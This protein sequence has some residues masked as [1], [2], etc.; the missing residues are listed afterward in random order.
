MVMLTSLKSTKIIVL[1]GLFN[2]VDLIPRV[3]W[4]EYEALN[5][6]QSTSNHSFVCSTGRERSLPGITYDKKGRYY[7]ISYHGICPHPEMK[8]WKCNADYK[9]CI[10]GTTYH[11]A[12]DS[13]TG[14]FTDACAS[15]VFCGKGKEPIIQFPE[16]LAKIDCRYCDEDHFSPA[17][18]SSDTYSEC[19]KKANCR[20]G[21]EIECLT[22]G[23][24]KY[25]T[26]RRC[27]CNWKMNYIPRNL[28]TLKNLETTEKFCLEDAT[29]I[30][31]ECNTRDGKSQQR[32]PDYSCAEVCDPDFHRINESGECVLKESNV[33]KEE[34][35]AVNVFS[36]PTT[37]TTTT[38]KKL[39]STL[40]TDITP[41]KSNN[42]S[43]TLPATTKTDDSKYWVGIVIGIAIMIIAVGACGFVVWCRFH[44]GD[45][46]RQ[47][48]KSDNHNPSPPGTPEYVS[49]TEDSIQ[50]RWDLPDGNEAQSFIAKYK[51]EIREDGQAWK[52][53]GE[54]NYNIYTARGLKQKTSYEF[55]V[56]TFYKGK[57]FSRVSDPIQLQRPSV[58]PE[59]RIRL[60]DLLALKGKPVIIRFIYKCTSVPDV[61]WKKG[62]D[63][64]EEED[65]RVT[66][67]HD[68][69]EAACVMEIRSAEKKDSGKYTVILRNE[70][71]SCQKSFQIIVKDVPGMPVGP[72]TMNNVRESENK[73]RLTW[74]PPEDNGGSEIDNYVV[75]QKSETGEWKAYIAYVRRTSCILDL[76]QEQQKYRFRVKAKNKQGYSVPCE[77]ETPLSAPKVNQEVKEYVAVEGNPYNVSIAYSGVPKPD[78]RWTKDG[79]AIKEES[80][81]IS[82]KTDHK[83]I[84]LELNPTVKTDRG[85]YSVKLRNLFGTDEVTFYV[86]IKYKPGKPEGP[87][88]VKRLTTTEF[89]LNWKP[90]QDPG[91][92]KVKYHVE[93][94][95][96]G[97]WVEKLIT[98]DTSCSFLSTPGVEQNRF[99]VMAENEQGY[100]ESLEGEPLEMVVPEIRT[101]LGDI[102]ARKGT[103]V[104][105]PVTYKCT[106]VPEVI[107]KKGDDVHEEEDDRVTFKHDDVEAACVMEVRSAE[108]KDSGKY[109][110]ILKNEKGSCQKSFQIIV[111]DVP[112]MPVGPL[113]VNNVLESENKYQL[114]W[115]APED[116]GGSEIDNYVVEQKS[117]TEEWEPY[118]TYVRETSCILDL[119]QERKKYRFRVKAQ[120]EQ[121]FS[122]PC[123][124]ETPFI[125]SKL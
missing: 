82:F 113:T 68:D 49:S 80:E 22:E 64:H 17:N 32:L 77:M 18:K 59:I 94:S 4:G 119:T 29:C 47:N 114:T 86:H 104:T 25:W 124:M 55:R 40:S 100:G 65:D 10:N 101:R 97:R 63:V 123:E 41:S 44:I 24:A 12:K 46:K 81:R 15:S 20:Q 1:L 21:E 38:Q 71:G 72:L 91:G 9:R 69:V 6:S 39:S 73:Y 95:E 106:S 108:R 13:I 87:L 19:A 88:T 26:Q 54:T 51:I 57:T 115:K 102:I 28:K 110:V 92:S 61:I 103:P 89:L 11:C 79:I 121:G 83:N 116:N 98:V 66:F 31:Y 56:T 53:L 99:R 5:Y 93:K 14:A 85:K 109:T 35:S 8:D 7:S 45:D 34:T 27:K 111:K 67:K 105:I 90:P 112:G 33:T 52:S 62:D 43:R 36:V 2:C 118:I 50:I 37:K 23:Y 96:S 107:W 60:G 48:G 30:F 75:E 3:D 74:K 125:L 16:G 42:D 120:N 70:K 84:S 122:V 76:T 78:V 117:E 58:V